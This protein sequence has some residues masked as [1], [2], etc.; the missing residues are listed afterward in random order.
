M[1]LPL[2]ALNLGWK[3]V[4]TTFGSTFIS[5]IEIAEG[6]VDVMR[7]TTAGRLELRWFFCTLTLSSTLRGS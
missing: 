3:L 7:G 2:T 5:G 1:P 6:R 4:E